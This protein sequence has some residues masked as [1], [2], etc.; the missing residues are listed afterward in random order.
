MSI[1]FH[2]F[3]DNS[4]FAITSICIKEFLAVTGDGHSSVRA[5]M[6]TE[7]RAAFQLDRFEKER[8]EVLPRIP[9]AGEVLLLEPIGNH[10]LG[11]KF[12]N[13]NYLIDPQ[14]EAVFEQICRQ[15]DGVLYGR[16][17]LKC[18]SVAALRRGEFLVMELNGIL[19]EPAH[20][21][22]PDY[23]MWRAYRDYYRHWK[24]IFDLYQAQRQRNI[25]PTAHRDAWLFVRQYFRYKKALEAR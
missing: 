24:I 17:D 5:L 12:L 1:L 23:G 16:F 13:G 3:P 9:Q 18:A 19:G 15:I 7:L 2:R 6:A 22:D 4:R 8:P 10:I 14:L 25:L 11:T 20:V 21:F